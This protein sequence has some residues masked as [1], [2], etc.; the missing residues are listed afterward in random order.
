[1]GASRNKSRIL[2]RSVKLAL[3]FRYEPAVLRHVADRLL[4][5]AQLL[6][7]KCQV[8]VAIGHGRVALQRSPV[9]LR[10]FRLAAEILE[11]H[12]EVVEQQR[13]GAPGV[14]RL[15]VRGLRFLEL[16]GLVQQVAAIDR[17]LEGGVPYR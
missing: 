17:V 13:I 5:P 12:P 2:R 10:R 7:E 1:M 6:A 16:A 8:V 9:S 3:L 15:A 11:Q 4:R 14:E